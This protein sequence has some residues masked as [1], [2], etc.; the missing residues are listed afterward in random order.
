MKRLVVMLS[1]FFLIA[2]GGSDTADTSDAGSA[3]DTPPVKAAGSSAP[4]AKAPS[5]PAAP[6]A[7]AAP[8]AD[9]NPQVTSCLGLVRQ[10]K[11]EAALPVCLAAL[12]ADPGNTEVQAAVE[13]ARAKTASLAAAAAGAQADAE[14]AAATADAAKA[15]DDAASQ[16][17]GMPGDAAG[18]LG[19]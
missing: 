13:A 4:A 7:P 6:T 11:L 1:M 3:S 5:A 12:E 15:A 8:S 2:C 17:K 19:Q 10:A 9:V 16:M 18:K 14:A